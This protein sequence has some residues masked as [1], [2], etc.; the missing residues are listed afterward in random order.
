MIAVLQRQSNNVLGC[1]NQAIE[2]ETQRVPPQTTLEDNKLNLDLD[3][4]RLLASSRELAMH[5][6]TAGDFSEAFEILKSKGSEGDVGTRIINEIKK[7]WS[8]NPEQVKAVILGV[9][10]GTIRDKAIW[11]YAVNIYDVEG[12]TGVLN[13][14]DQMHD[15]REKEHILLLQAIRCSREDKAEDLKLIAAS[16]HDSIPNVSRLCGELLLEFEK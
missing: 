6:G 4:E 14:V 7:Y 9:N 10:P 11:A 8:D 12:I 13:W 5:L 15:V 3:Q 1:S 16:F 2:F